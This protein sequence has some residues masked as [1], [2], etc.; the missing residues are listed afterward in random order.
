MAIDVIS[1]Y[2]PDIHAP[3][4]VSGGSEDQFMIFQALG[5]APRQVTSDDSI[6]FT[7]AAFYGYSTVDSDGVPT[8]NA[9]DVHIGGLAIDGNEI[10]PNTV[11]PGG[12]V[13]IQAPVGKS[14]H[15]SDVWIKADN[16]ADGLIVELA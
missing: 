2:I 13:I 15:L 3:P 12:E 7:V 11:S 10:L 14:F 8:D 9:D 5:T 16:G 4:S 1:A 6:Q